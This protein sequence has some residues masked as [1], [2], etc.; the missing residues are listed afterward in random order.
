VEATGRVNYGKAIVDRK[1]ITEKVTLSDGTSEKELKN[2]LVYN[3]PV[4]YAFQKKVHFTNKKFNG[5]GWYKGSFDLA[6]TGDSFL[7]VSTWGKG[8]VWVNGHNLGRFW[9]IGPQQAMYVPGVWLK[10]GK[11]EIIVLDVEGPSKTGIAGLSNPILNRINP[12]ASLLHRAKGQTLNLSGAAPVMS[13]SFTEGTGWKE[14]RFDQPVEGRYFC[15]EALS[16]QKPNDPL[17]TIAEIELIGV[18]D[19]PLSSLKWKVLYAESE[20]ITAGNFG[21]DRI[22]DQ[23]ESTFWQTQSI[24]AKPPYPHQVV[25]D[26]GSIEMIKGFR[27]L[28]RSDKKNDGMIKEYRVF[29]KKEA[30]VF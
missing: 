14:V 18:D 15:L 19:K 12:D 21:A 26:L 17:A 30:F 11:N 5:S 29:V 4:D 22:F 10:K 7:D 1:G 8:M 3:F 24:G 9:K 25:L 23:Q 2:W 28:P 6:K 16:A 20:E 27:Y 13:G